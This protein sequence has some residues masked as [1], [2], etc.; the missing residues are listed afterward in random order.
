MATY[1]EEEVGVGREGDEDDEREQPPG[2][3]SE[4]RHEEAH[5]R[6]ALAEAH[7]ADEEEGEGQVGRD[8]LVELFGEEQVHHRRAHAHQ[9]QHPRQTS[10][11]FFIFVNCI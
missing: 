11:I 1:I 8:G 7:H 5:A 3:S 4:V 2:G 10:P 6:R 9:A